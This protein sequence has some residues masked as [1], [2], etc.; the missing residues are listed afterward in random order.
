MLTHDICVEKVPAF[1]HSIH[2]F[3]EPMD[4]FLQFLQCVAVNL[5]LDR[6]IS[7]LFEELRILLRQLLFCILSLLIRLHEL[8]LYI[9]I[10]G[11][12][13]LK[14]GGCSGK[15]GRCTYYN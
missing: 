11:S 12:Q 8:C 7:F 13:V 3:P 2:V 6:K 1:L 15:G 9:F 10:R 4:F 5:P 14:L